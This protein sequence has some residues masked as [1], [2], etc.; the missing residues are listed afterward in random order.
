MKFYI[1]RLLNKIRRVRNERH[2][3]RD[4]LIQHALEEKVRKHPN[5]LNKGFY[6]GFS[7]NEEDQIILEIVQRLRLERGY[8]VEFGVGKGLENN[9]L[10]LLAKKW[11][12]AWFGGETLQIKDYDPEQL[13]FEKVRISKDNVAG[14]LHKVNHHPNLISVD[15]DGNDYYLVEELLEKG[16]SP[17]IFIVEHN[18]KF[19]P[20]IEFVIDYDSKHRWAGDDYF[21]ASLQSFVDLLAKF[22]YSLVCC[23]IPGSNAFFVKNEHK[24]LFSDIPDH[25][26]DI[27]NPPFYF[28]FRG[29]SHPL[30]L[31]TIKKILNK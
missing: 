5:T 20:P 27:Y 10:I 3:I 18:A 4:L 6:R 1:Q 2:L 9:S 15:L 23:N 16:A 30:S 22:N 12:G 11:R 7:Q 17:E 31:R 24:A 28:Q 13:R 14:L 26:R 25:I 8:F 19:P 21:G 29:G